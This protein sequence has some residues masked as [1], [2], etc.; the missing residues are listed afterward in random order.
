[1]YYVNIIR[2]TYESYHDP[3]YFPPPPPVVNDWSLSQD[4]LTVYNITTFVFLRN[5]LGPNK[6]KKQNNPV[7][8]GFLSLRDRSFT[9]RGRWRKSGGHNMKLEKLPVKGWF[10]MQKEGRVS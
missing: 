9:M 3:P 5:V 2:I 8:K 6:S 4:D 7:S 10:I 1:M